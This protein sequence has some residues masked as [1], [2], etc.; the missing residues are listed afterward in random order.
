MVRDGVLPFVRL[1][2]RR[3]RIPAASV[4]A[5]TRHVKRVTAVKKKRQY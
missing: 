5:L 4:R 3:L 1:G 2:R